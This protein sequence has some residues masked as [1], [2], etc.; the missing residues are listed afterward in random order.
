MD[1]CGYGHAS[2]TH[3]WMAS[4]PRMSVA[5]M[6]AGGAGPRGSTE[7]AQT[8]ETTATALAVLRGSISVDV[9]SHGGKTGIISKAPPSGDLAEAMRAG[10]LAVACLADV[11]DWPVL[12]RSADGGL[13]AT[14]APRP[15]EFY[16]YHLDR[17]AWMDE[18]VTHHGVRRALCAADLEAAHEAGEP[19][20]IADVEGL[21][22]LE[23]KLE[24]L[25]EA[26]QRGIR[27]VQLVHYTPNDIGDFQ[28]GA[29]TH[30]GLTGFGAEVVRAC[31]RLGFVC[32]VAHA[33][34]EMAKQVVRVAT[35]PMLLS[36]TAVL[37]SRAMGRTPLRGRQVSR[38][39]A[40]A[41]AETGGA[42]GIW[43][44]FPSLERYVDGLK[45][46]AEIVGV[47]H[48]SIG[49]DQFDS[50]GC[51]DDYTR[52]VHLVAAMLRG[53]FS[54]EEAGK[55]AGGN[56]MCIFRAAVG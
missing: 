35:K 12:G 7:A 36:H 25:E 37:G 9:H 32:D 17:L 49:T 23:L 5:A 29:I 30:Q 47:D 11:P 40:R 46:M 4:M 34:E 14:R 8:A 55:I 28:T 24:R 51:L 52:W 16:R 13:A 56:Y 20:I 41:I 15:G 54:A 38:D 3:P 2:V 6:L 48:V 33:T 1:C 45:E 19:A 10:S 50:R 39:H 27:H 21:D 44:F 42:V 22:F 43:H 31:D 53:G 18:L 26:H